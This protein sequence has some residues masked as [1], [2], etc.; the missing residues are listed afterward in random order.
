MTE[1]KAILEIKIE[2]DRPG[3]SIDTKRG[4]VSMIPFSGRVCGEIFNGI[5]EPWGVDT[6]IT[7]HI[8]IRILSARYMLSG[9]DKEGNDCHIYVEN[10]AWQKADEFSRTFD[11]LPV[12]YTDSPALADYLHCDRFIGQGTVQED[13]LWIR[14]YEK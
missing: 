9:K 14:F 13:G 10:K 12:F 4:K 3:L 8:D 1:R 5:V 7:N 6:Q 2:M 11:S